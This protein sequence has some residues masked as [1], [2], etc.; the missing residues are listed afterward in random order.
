MYKTLCKFVMIFT[1]LNNLLKV[2]KKDF[3][4]KKMFS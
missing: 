2:I 1:N 3:L 4:K